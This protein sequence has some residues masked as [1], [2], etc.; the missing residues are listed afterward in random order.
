MSIRLPAARRRRQLLDMALEVFATSGFHATSMDQ[1]AE[2]AGVTKPVLYQHFGSK[3]QLYLDLLGDVGDQMMEA[4]TKATAEAETPREQV[5]A[6]F[7]GYFGFAARQAD[8]FRLLFGSD[9]RTD[10]EFADAAARVEQAVADA[11]APLI[12]ADI[13]EDHRRLAAQA[14]VGLAEAVSRRWAA[15]GLGDDPEVLARRSADLAWAGLRGIRR[16]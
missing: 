8:A 7:R 3:R 1:V 2:A 15:G 10:N 9:A 6:G 13:D 12:E 11:I 14:V 4:I 5:V 16:D